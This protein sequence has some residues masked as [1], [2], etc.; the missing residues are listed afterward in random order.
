MAH[1]VRVIVVDPDPELP[2][3]VVL[4]GPCAAVGYA[5]LAVWWAFFE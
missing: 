1:R 5:A 2:S 3:K 4:L